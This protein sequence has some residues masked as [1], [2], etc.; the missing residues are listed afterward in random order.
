MHL[1]CWNCLE[2]FL[3]LVTGLPHYQPLMLP[4][5]SQNRLSNTDR[6]IIFIAFQIGKP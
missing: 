3:H 2:R 1:E 5:I 6:N 4:L